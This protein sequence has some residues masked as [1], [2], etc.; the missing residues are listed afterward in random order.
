MWYMWKFHSSLTEMSPNQSYF[1]NYFSVLKPWMYL[2]WIFYVKQPSDSDIQI[3]LQI[4]DVKF[5]VT[6]NLPW[7]VD[8]EMIWTIHH[9]GLHSVFSMMWSSSNSSEHNFLLSTEKPSSTVVQSLMSGG[10]LH[11]AAKTVIITGRFWPISYLIVHNQIRPYPR[12]LK[13]DCSAPS[14]HLCGSAWH[15]CIQYILI[16]RT[17]TNIHH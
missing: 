16:W 13:Q 9:F 10:V 3:L 11:N 5:N 4:V 15:M 2:K 17:I 6:A 14:S 1:D 8:F 7:I 12:L